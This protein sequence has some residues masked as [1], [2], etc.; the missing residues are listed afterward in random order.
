[1][2]SLINFAADDG[3]EALFTHIAD[4]VGRTAGF[5]HNQIGWMSIEQMV[6][7]R[8]LGGDR[9]ES[10]LAISGIA[11]AA[12]GVELAEVH[13]KDHHESAPWFEGSVFSETN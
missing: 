2:R 4:P 7:M 6:K 1:M 3:V 5:H 8:S 13:R 12:D 10:T 11:G 9:L